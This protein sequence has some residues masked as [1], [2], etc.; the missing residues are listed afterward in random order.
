LIGCGK[1]KKLFRNFQAYFAKKY[2]DYTENTLDFAEIQTIYNVDNCVF[3]LFFLL[4]KLLS[5]VPSS[6]SSL[7]IYLYYP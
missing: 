1:N 7:Y 5:E 2:V 4:S 3:P 6:S